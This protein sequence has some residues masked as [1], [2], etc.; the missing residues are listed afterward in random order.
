MSLISRINQIE[1]R[2]FSEKAFI[3]D[4]VL[5]M[6]DNGGYWARN[7]SGKLVNYE[8]L[9]PHEKAHNYVILSKRK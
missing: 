2:I 5:I 9:K 1:E 6:K 4:F 3:P 8:E 7:E